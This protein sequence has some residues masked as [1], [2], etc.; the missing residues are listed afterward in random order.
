MK[1]F[2]AGAAMNDRN[3]GKNSLDRNPDAGYNGD[4]MWEL[5]SF[6]HRSLLCQ[7]VLTWVPPTLVKNWCIQTFDLLLLTG[8]RP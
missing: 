5:G 3:I 4:L 1:A 8:E 2:D 7:Y 6:L